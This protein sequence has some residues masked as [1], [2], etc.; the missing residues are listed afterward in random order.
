VIYV[1]TKALSLDVVFEAVTLF[2]FEELAR[3][4]F[5]EGDD[6]SMSG[7]EASMGTQQ[8]KR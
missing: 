7:F 8:E 5:P 6:Y 4:N 1:G 3:L 2:W